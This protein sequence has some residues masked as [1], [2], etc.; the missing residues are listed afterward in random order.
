MIKMIFSRVCICI[1]VSLCFPNDIE[2]T[3]IVYKEYLYIYIGIY[4][5]YDFLSIYIYLWNLS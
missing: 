4:I 2:Q 1:S 5:P 3:R